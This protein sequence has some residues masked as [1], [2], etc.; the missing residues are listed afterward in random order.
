MD[1]YLTQLYVKNRTGLT[2]FL[3]HKF[4]LIKFAA[5]SFIISKQTATIV[6]FCAT[7]TNYGRNA[8]KGCK[9]MGSASI[10]SVFCDRHIIL[11][12]TFIHLHLR[13][14]LHTSAGWTSSALRK[15]LIP[16]NQKML[17]TLNCTGNAI[18]I[19]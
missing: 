14:F 17:V 4:M 12:F 10:Y 19:M 1:H 13:S 18:N 11:K 8:S 15:F 9:L 2:A 7:F 5:D 3:Y 6:L 16:A